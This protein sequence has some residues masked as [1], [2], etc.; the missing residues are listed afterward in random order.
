M[1][2]VNCGIETARKN[3]YKA[4]L[5][6]V[7]GSGYLY[8]SKRSDASVMPAIRG[9]RMGLNPLLQGLDGLTTTA[10]G[11]AGKTWDDQTTLSQ[12]TVWLSASV[13]G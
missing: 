13:A 10:G 9:L 11:L 7:Q 8:A 4:F 12:L 2:Q 1:A 6:D 5:V 3:G